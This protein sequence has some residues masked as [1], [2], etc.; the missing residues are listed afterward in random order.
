MKIPALGSFFFPFEIF[1]QADATD[2][3]QR[4]K[5]FCA[6]SECTSSGR[7]GI[8]FWLEEEQRELD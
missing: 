1:L 5:G 8:I 7:I 6:L 4:A 2:A 3:Q